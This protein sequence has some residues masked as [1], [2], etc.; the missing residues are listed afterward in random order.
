MSQVSRR[1]RGLETANALVMP[2]LSIKV[3][4][5]VRGLEKIPHLFVVQATVSRR[6]RGLEMMG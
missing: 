3:S 1:V 4:R 2:E 5:R 6:V